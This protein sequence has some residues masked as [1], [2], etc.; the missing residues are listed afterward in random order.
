L[1]TG[2]L[3]N[4]LLTKVP[5]SGPLQTYNFPNEEDPYPDFVRNKYNYARELFKFVNQIVFDQKLPLDLKIEWSG[6]LRST[7]GITRLMLSGSDYLAKIDLSS[8][9]INHPER[10][11]R[12][13][14]H[15]LCHAAVWIIHHNRNDHHG[16]IWQNWMRRAKARF[17]QLQ[18]ATCHNYQ[19]DYKYN[20]RCKQC[21]TEVGRH[22]IWN[23]FDKYR[24]K[25][26]GGNFYLASMRK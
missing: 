20:Y 9:I 5:S 11:C 15:E 26:C 18:V 22:K 1:Q 2:E 25:R 3:I 14:I 23:N 19:I 17:P 6:R 12:T 16:P 7:A 8:V 10:L 4:N 24:C 13:L 21:S